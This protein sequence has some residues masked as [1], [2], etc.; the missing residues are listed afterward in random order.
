MD[1]KEEMVSWL[2]GLTTAELRGQGI[3][4]E[5]QVTELQKQIRNKHKA[6]LEINRELNRRAQ[7]GL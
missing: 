5:I 4:L 6:T 3:S 1:S 7:E 2:R